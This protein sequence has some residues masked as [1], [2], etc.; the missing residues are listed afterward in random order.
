MKPLRV[1]LVED[2]D[3]DEALVL[4]ELKESGFEVSHQRVETAQA[5]RDA[6]RV[7]SSRLIRRVSSSPSTPGNR[8]STRVRRGHA[9]RSPARLA[10]PDEDAPERSKPVC[11]KAIARAAAA[12]TSYC[13]A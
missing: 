3:D 6:L 11:S 4:R 2:S 12:R 13:A 8:R 1:L 5:M 7:R 10:R 9:A